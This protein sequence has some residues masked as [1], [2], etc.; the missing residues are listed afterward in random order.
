[1]TKLTAAHRRVLCEMIGECDH[2]PDKR[3]PHPAPAHFYC[4]RCEE[5]IYVYAMKYR[6]FTNGNDMVLVKEAIEKSGE[7]EEFCRSFAWGRY[8]HENPEGDSVGYI[9]W[10]LQPERFAYLAAEWKMGEGK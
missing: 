9:S 8:K 6:P 10:L 4:K 5:P 3:R 2:A 1:M 7:W